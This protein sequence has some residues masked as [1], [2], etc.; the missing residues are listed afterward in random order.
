M[1][2]GPAGIGDLIQRCGPLTAHL[3]LRAFLE[4]YSI[5]AM[6]LAR[7]GGDAVS[8]ERAFMT[9]CQGLGRQRLLQRR[10][11]SPES[12]S[13][14]LFETGLQLASNFGLVDGGDNMSARRADFAGELKHL[15]RELGA[16]EELALLDFKSLLARN[17][18]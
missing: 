10:I 3:T 5:V 16:I 12:L 7:L 9:A 8:D 1:T 17:R 6:S 13:R 2:L 15:L 11:L 18:S 14:H 4:A